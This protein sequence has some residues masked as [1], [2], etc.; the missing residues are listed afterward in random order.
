MLASQYAST[1]SATASSAFA[2]AT[3]AA[4]DGFYAAA[5]APAQ[6][7]DYVA[8]SLDAARDYV[9][10]SWNDNQVRD[11]AIQ[12]GYIKSNS[13]AKRDEVIK[14]ISD[15]TPDVY[16][17]WSDSCV[18]ASAARL[19][20][21]AASAAGSRATASS[22]ARRPSRAMSSS[23]SSR[24]TTTARATRR[25]SAS[26]MRL[27]RPDLRS[28]WSDN[29]IKRW[30]QSRGLIKSDAQVTAEECVTRGGVRS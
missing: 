6:A 15:N 16:G 20:V 14:A 3:D 2:K 7:Y 21:A 26:S 19:T 5:D 17:T 30:L 28:F 22:R 24:A 9:Y 27:T 29:T 8:G 13:Q 23:T 18:D 1:A 10:S 11:Y 4:T 12:H 25:T